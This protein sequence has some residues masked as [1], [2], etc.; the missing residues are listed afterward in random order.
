MISHLPSDVLEHVLSF[1][2]VHTC[3]RFL[4]S[5]KYCSL[6]TQSV[7]KKKRCFSIKYNNNIVLNIYKTELQSK[8]QNTTTTSA[9]VKKY[10][11]IPL[12]SRHTVPFLDKFYINQPIFSQVCIESFID[13]KISRNSVKKTIKFSYDNSKMGFLRVCKNGIVISIRSNARRR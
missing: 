1:C 5:E 11:D 13:A 8:N 10:T 7:L 4:Q 2:S 12:F 6:I 3:V 9:Y